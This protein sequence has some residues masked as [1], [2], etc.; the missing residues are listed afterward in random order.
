ML[1]WT[2]NSAAMQL[3]HGS[4]N[5]KTGRRGKR[6]EQD[7]T[8]SSKPQRGAKKVKEAKEG[9]TFQRANVELA[10]PEEMDE[11]VEVEPKNNPV[12]E[13]DDEDVDKLLE[14]EGYGAEGSLLDTLTGKPEAED[15]LH[16][17]IPVVGPYGA[18]K[19]YKYHVKMTPG[20]GKKG[21][22]AKQAQ[23]IFCALKVWWFFWRHCFVELNIISP[24]KKESTERE[25]QLIKAAKEEEMTR[26]MPGKVK[27][28]G[29]NV[30]QQKKKK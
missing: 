17:A 9:N 10:A 3:L 14:E 11:K 20:T 5:K 4:T 29:A 6:N 19:D 1:F 7:K 22:T 23:S 21:K 25:A 26:N 13:D 30:N 12:V 2:Q 24:G 15:I 8:S 18:V 28:S 16:F 27:L